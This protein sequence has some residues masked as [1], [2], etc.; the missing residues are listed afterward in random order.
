VEKKR[1]QW[2]TKTASMA[3]TLSQSMSYLRSFMG[4]PPVMFPFSPASLALGHWIAFGL[5]PN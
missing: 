1:V 4:L 3:M 2:K 5:P